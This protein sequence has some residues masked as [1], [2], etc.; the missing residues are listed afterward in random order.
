MWFTKTLRKVPEMSNMEIE[1]Y[2]WWIS[3][4]TAKFVVRIGMKRLDRVNSP[5]E[6]STK[7]D[8]Y[9]KL[10]GMKNIFIYIL[11][12]HFIIL[13]HSLHVEVSR[14]DLFAGEAPCGNSNRLRWNFT[15]C[16][17]DGHIGQLKMIWVKKFETQVEK[18]LI[19]NFLV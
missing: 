10:S 15:T 19:N 12:V 6:K 3:A 2:N 13:R 4:W 18:T 5:K 16:S 17:F 9:F 7:V 11:C 14:L 8:V 1:C